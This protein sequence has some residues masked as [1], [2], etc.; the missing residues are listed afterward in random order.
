M[1]PRSISCRS[2]MP[3]AR[4]SS[5]ARA[6][7]PFGCPARGRSMTDVAFVI[8]HPYVDALACFREPIKAL[9]ALGY[10]VDVYL[11]FTAWHPAPTFTDR[12]IRFIPLEVSHTGTAALVTQLIAR[13][14]RY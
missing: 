11:R 14:P 7:G 8:E 9:A 10:G 13:R 5:R 3:R 2:T 12:H 4:T 6:P 1:R